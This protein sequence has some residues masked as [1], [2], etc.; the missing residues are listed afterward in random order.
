MMMSELFY[1]CYHL[2]YGH[3][4]YSSVQWFPYI[5]LFVAARHIFQKAYT[6]LNKLSTA[7]FK[8]K[9]QRGCF[10]INVSLK[11]TVRLQKS[12]I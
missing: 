10:Y 5:E 11:R 9:M 8:I 2:D 12:S 6:S 7:R 4:T 3:L 1:F